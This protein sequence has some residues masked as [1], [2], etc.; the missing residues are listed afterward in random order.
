MRWEGADGRTEFAKAAR[1]PSALFDVGVGIQV[2]ELAFIAAIA[3]TC[4]QR[5]K[6]KRKKGKAEV[7]KK[8]DKIALVPCVLKKEQ[9]GI[10]RRLY[11]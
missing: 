4:S 1:V 5:R 8:A 2:K 3:D 10:F 9:I 7:S 6:K 11:S